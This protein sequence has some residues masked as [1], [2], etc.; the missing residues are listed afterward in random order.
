[1]ECQG[2][3]LKTQNKIEKGR[4]KRGEEGKRGEG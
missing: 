1:M 2:P 3:E 4:E